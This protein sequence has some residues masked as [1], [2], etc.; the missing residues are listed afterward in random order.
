MSQDNTTHPLALEFRL[1]KWLEIATPG[2]SYPL[3]RHEVACLL[4][5]INRLRGSL[6]IAGERNLAA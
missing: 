3:D 2:W 1:R 6:E 5:E 4:N